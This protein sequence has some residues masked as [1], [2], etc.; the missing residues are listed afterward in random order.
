[1]K[2]GEVMTANEIYDQIAR[3]QI[4]GLTYSR[5]LEHLK[6]QVGRGDLISAPAEI[7]EVEHKIKLANAEID[8]LNQQLKQ[9]L[10]Q[11]PKT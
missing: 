5:R 9:V 4:E 2:N 7:A 3:I 1:M 8:A 6:F 11:S 10:E